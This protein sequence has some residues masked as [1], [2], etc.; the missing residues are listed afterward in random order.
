MQLFRIK[1]EQKSEDCDIIISE[2]SNSEKH[3]HHM[4]QYRKKSAKFR[5]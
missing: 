3:V 2:C 1:E 4:K 5:Y